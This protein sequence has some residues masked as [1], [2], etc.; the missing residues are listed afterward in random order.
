MRHGLWIALAVVAGL[1]V[2][3]FA[4]RYFS[5][6]R[7]LAPAELADIALTAE[8]PQRRGGA[9]AQLIRH[10]EAAREELRRVLAESD[11]DDVKSACIQALAAIHDYDSMNN[12]LDALEDPSPLVRARAGQTVDQLLGATYGFSYDA[13]QDVRQRQIEFLR[14]EWQS[15]KE[16]EGFE[17][18]VERM[19]RQ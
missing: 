7:L 15:L 18:F 12:I 3:V 8:D 6:D 17:H 16:S 5:R 13:P 14:K 1:A 4:W 11:N 2:V 19:K 9:A 10:G